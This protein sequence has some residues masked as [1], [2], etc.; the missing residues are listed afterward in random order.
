MN[1]AKRPS[2]LSSF[3]RK[4]AREVAE[5]LGLGLVASGCAALLMFT[6]GTFTV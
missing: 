5:A 1:S 2:W 3:I 4:Y 6:S